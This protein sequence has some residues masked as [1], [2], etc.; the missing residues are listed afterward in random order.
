MVRRELM[1]ARA[2]VYVVLI[3]PVDGS[4]ISSL[5]VVISMKNV[6][7]YE[8]IITCILHFVN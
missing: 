6:S 5:S 8:L 7:L 2:L 4:A 3:L 1:S